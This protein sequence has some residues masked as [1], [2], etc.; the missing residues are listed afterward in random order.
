VEL[1]A[2]GEEKL[3]PLQRELAARTAEFESARADWQ[4]S[5][6]TMTAK[7]AAVL[8]KYAAKKAANHQL[9]AEGK[10]AVRPARGG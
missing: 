7:H 8:E 5:V 1:E 10:Q 3:A 2:V 9:V 6:K 4:K